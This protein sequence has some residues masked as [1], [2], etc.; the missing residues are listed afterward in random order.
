MVGLYSV[1]Y[2]CYNINGD[3]IDFQCD[4][5]G[6]RSE[7]VVVGQRESRERIGK[8]SERNNRIIPTSAWPA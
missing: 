1:Q 4:F 8:D 2:H 6:L 3:S 7:M 5:L